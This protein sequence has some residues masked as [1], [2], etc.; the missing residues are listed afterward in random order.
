MLKKKITY[1]DYDG[2]ERTEEF[3]FN[4]NKA[5]LTQME[6]SKEG[7]LV[8]TIEK[9]VETN[10]SKQLVD[11]FTELILKSYGE[12]S[13]D[14]KRFI[15][16]QELTDAFSQTEAYSELFML[17]ATDADE[18]AAFVNGITQSVQSSNK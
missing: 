17:L 8:K 6:M 7:G 3:H 14:G 4:L 15:K 11:I 12:K 16:N 9:I 18:A 5:E 1:V 10:D 2:V 13:V